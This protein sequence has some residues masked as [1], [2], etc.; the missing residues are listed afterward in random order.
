MCPHS[1]TPLSTPTADQAPNQSA[2]RYPVS[3][4]GLGLRRDLLNELETRPAEVSFVEAAPENWINIGGKVRER[5]DR[6]VAHY[7]LICHGLSLSLGGPTALDTSLLKQIKIFL[8]THQARYYS[9]HLSACTGTGHLYDLMPVPFTD[10]AVDYVAARIRQTQDILERKIAIENT[11]A[12]LA[13]GNEMPE[14]DFL[15]KTLESADCKLLLD[16][17]NVYVNSVNFNFDPIAY[18]HSLSAD[19]IAYCHIAGHSDEAEDL[20]VDTHGSDIIPPVWDLLDETYKRFGVIP[21]LLERD[22]NFPPFAD[23]LKEL[24][25]INRYQQR[26]ST[27]PRH[28]S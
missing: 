6:L 11:S 22:F 10:D 20:I 13:P 15:N 17:N 9:E 28:A 16:V 24:R 23:L 7:P 25:M 26:Y 8:D 14:I 12:Y 1:E 27:A 4:G 2:R 19:R 21:T 18:L 3:G 5:F